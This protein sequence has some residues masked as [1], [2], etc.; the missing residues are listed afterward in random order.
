[1][2]QLPS[3]RGF[4]D[5]TPLLADPPRLRALAEQEGYLF[6]KSFLPQEPLLELR[7]QIL[8]IVQR[9]HWL[10]PGTPLLE[11]RA[12]LKAIAQSE[13]TD[14]SLAFIGVTKAA[15][16]EIQ[17]LELFHA[18]PHHPRLLALYN[19]LLAPPVL[20]HPRHIA[21]VLMPSP[22][23]APTPPHQDYV[24]IQG[25]HQF[26]TCWFPL[27]DCPLALGGLSVLRGSHR[28]PVLDVSR[29]RGA[30][31][32][33]SILCHQ[34]HTWIEDDYTCGDILTFPSHLIHKGLP[35]QAGTHLRLSC[36]LRYQSAQEPIEGQSLQPHAYVATWDELY[37]GW[38]NEDLQYYWQKHSLQTSPWNPDLLQAKERIC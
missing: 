37:A 6:F 23:F 30:G 33:E 10:Q 2:P 35:N 34:N 15:Y 4:I 27:G 38:K 16:R 28:E 5:A 20:P 19:L 29:A 31:G 18:L 7:R 26:W 8:E 1:M 17:S 36:D 14:P 3:V 21:R 11:G 13:E 25:S 24:Y 22:R 32:F 12:N 9:H